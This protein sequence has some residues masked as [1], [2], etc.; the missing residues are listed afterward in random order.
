MSIRDSRIRK[1]SR[2]DFIVEVLWTSDVQRRRGARL[3]GMSRPSVH[4][5]GAV[6]VSR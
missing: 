1:T 2:I 6:P 3:A 4:V 5:R